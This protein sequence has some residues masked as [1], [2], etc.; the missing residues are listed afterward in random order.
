MI[1]GEIPAPSLSL[2]NRDVMLRHLNAIAFGAAQPGLAGRMD[3]YVSPMGEIRDEAFHE[4][5]EA[6]RAQFDHASVW[7]AKHLV[8]TFSWLPSSMRPLCGSI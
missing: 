6:I 1:A 8:R 7:E 5:I 3:A 4:L 2:G